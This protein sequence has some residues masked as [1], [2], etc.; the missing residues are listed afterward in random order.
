MAEDKGNPDAAQDE[1]MINEWAQ[2]ELLPIFQQISARR[3]PAV[4]RSGVSN[5]D[6]RL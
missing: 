4:V 5:C 6:A 2:R 3:K 1:S